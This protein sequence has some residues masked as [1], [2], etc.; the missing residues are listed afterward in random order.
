[1][2]FGESMF[3]RETDASKIAFVTLARRLAAMDFR[4]IDCQMHT[5]HLKS[6]GATLRSRREYMQ[7]LSEG[8][9]R[10]TLRGRWV[11]AGEVLDVRTP[12]ATR[13]PVEQQRAGPRVSTAAL[14]LG[15]LGA[16][17]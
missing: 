3:S 6:M 11:A 14:S 17:L 15:M 16:R 5:D 10:P 7:E 13:P 1:M 9:S 12:I 4:L 8:M 2:F